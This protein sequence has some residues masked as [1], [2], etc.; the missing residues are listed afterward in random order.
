M[1]ILAIIP[2]YNEARNITAVIEDLKCF[3]G[4]ILVVNDGSTDDTAAVAKGLGA[5]VVSHPF[6]LGIGGT[7]QTGLRYAYEHGYDM[8]IQF[9]GDGQHRGDQIFKIVELVQ[10]GE[11]DL[12]I[13]SRTL[14][15]G[16]KMGIT[17]FIGSRIFH[18]L[19]R[20]LAGKAIHDPTSGFRCYGKQTIRLFSRFYTDDYPEVESIITAARNG[21]RV[22]EVPVLMRG[23]LSGHSSITRRKSAYYMLKVTLAMV[24]DAMRGRDLVGES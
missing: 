15:G 18:C 22:V 16:Y 19:I 20:C 5:E 13:G 10:R 4:D 11:A 2:A 8:A 9:D 17:R 6:N 12:V 1:R 23:R 7:V 24:V 14:P 21:L 3:S